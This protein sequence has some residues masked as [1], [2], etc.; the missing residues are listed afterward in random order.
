MV[1]RGLVIEKGCI[2]RCLE[3]LSPLRR[4]PR[5]RQLEGLQRTEG[6]MSY[7]IFAVKAAVVVIA[8]VVVFSLLRSFSQKLQERRA[9]LGSFD[10]WAEVSR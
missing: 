2:Q 6:V 10:V 8:V 5:S 1:S 3:R 9:C 4:P 7:A